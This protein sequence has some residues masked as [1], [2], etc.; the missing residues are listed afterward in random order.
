MQSTIGHKVLAVVPLDVFQKEH[1]AN[2]RG[3]TT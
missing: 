1:L 3:P 2:L